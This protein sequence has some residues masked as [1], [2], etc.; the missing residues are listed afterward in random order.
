MTDQEFKQKVR[1]SSAWR[2]FREH[3][4]DTRR[5]DEVTLKPL[6]KNFNLHHM[7]FDVSHYD[8][9]D[10]NNFSCLNTNT[11][12]VIHFLYRYYKKDKA[13]LGRIQFILDRM[14]E[15]NNE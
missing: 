11:H 8:V 6:R 12:D 15:L 14:A 9:F 13:I 7:D 4:R 10:E 2:K 3:M 5:V 1:K